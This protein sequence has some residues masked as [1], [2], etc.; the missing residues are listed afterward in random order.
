[1]SNREIQPLSFACPHCT[2]LINLTLTI[3]KG[4]KIS[5]ASQ[6]EGK[7]Y[8]LFDGRNPFI[9]LHLDFPVWFNP[10]VPGM[11]PF[12]VAMNKILSDNKGEN[13]RL[14]MQFHNQRINQLNN[15][16]EKSEQIR[17]I[18]NLYSG[19]NKQ[20]FKKRVEQFLNTELGESIKPEDVNAAL[21][22]FI[23]TV[24][25]PFINIDEVRDLVNGLNVV[26]NDLATKKGFA[27]NSFMDN[28]IQTNFLNTIQKDCLDLYPEIYSAE[29]PLRP[30]LFLDLVEGY[31][32]NKIAARVSTADFK[33][34]KDLYKDIAEVFGRQLILVAGINN[35]IHRDDFNSFSKPENGNALSSL[36]KFA[37]KTLSDKFKYLDDSWYLVDNKT[38]DTKIRNAI[39]HFTAE[40]N[41]VTQIITYFPE[42]DG[43]K[44]ER[45]ETMFFLDFM[46]MLLSLFREV[47]HLHHLIKALFYFEYLIRQK[48]TSH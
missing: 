9:D 3:G 45:G 32:R 5:G 40:Y 4:V 26:L 23:S 44:Q 10:Y 13:G 15:F 7:Q 6:D 37:D 28:I 17:T 1:M 43:V 46:R 42:K 8:G 31:E 2:S 20:L 39:A 11:T 21:Y 48:K 35:I 30:A 41:E 14:L 33:T 34:F 38:V 16:H 22:K 12:M 27:F 47:H 36:D 25:L 29:L 24:F 19:R 18:V